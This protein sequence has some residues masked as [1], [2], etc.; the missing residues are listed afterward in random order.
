[1]FAEASHGVA[2]AD[3]DGV[4]QLGQLGH[5]DQ[6]LDVSLSDAAGTGVP[7]AA[8]ERGVLGV[9]NDRLRPVWCQGAVDSARAI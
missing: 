4:G 7:D 6:A 3:V 8:G 2:D 1:M 9:L 5:E